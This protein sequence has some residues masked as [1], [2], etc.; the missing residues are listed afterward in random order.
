MAGHPSLADLF[1]SIESISWIIAG[2]RRCPVLPDPRVA[3]P[4]SRFLQLAESFGALV[5]LSRDKDFAK[6]L[7]VMDPNQEHML[8]TDDHVVHEAYGELLN[9]LS[10]L[11][12]KESY[13][14]LSYSRLEGRNGINGYGMYLNPLFK[15]IFDQAKGYVKNKLGDTDDFVKYLDELIPDGKTS[16]NEY[17]GIVDKIARSKVDPGLLEI[18]E[19]ITSYVD[20]RGNLMPIAPDEVPTVQTAF[21]RHQMLNPEDGSSFVIKE[22]LEEALGYTLY[23]EDPQ[24]N[25]SPLRGNSAIDT[26]I[27]NRNIAEFQEWYGTL[28]KKRGHVFFIH[29]ASRLEILLTPEEQKQLTFYSET[30]DSLYQPSTVTFQQQIAEPEARVPWSLS[31]AWDKIK[32]LASDAI[33]GG[34]AIQTQTV[35]F[36]TNYIEMKTKQI[37][38][39]GVLLLGGLNPRVFN[40]LYAPAQRLSTEEFFQRIHEKLEGYVNG[41]NI[42]QF[43]FEQEVETRQSMAEPR[44]QVNP[45]AASFKEDPSDVDESLLDYMKQCHARGRNMYII[46]L[47]HFLRGIGSKPDVEPESHQ[48]FAFVQYMAALYTQHAINNNRSLSSDYLPNAVVKRQR[49]IATTV[50]EKRILLDRALGVDSD[51]RITSFD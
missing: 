16:V 34:P 40:I 5:N 29:Y 18:V 8:I 21:G 28:V 37:D 13:R 38:F 36:I 24:N 11:R 41:L 46:C 6:M 27:R 14:E 42:R 35:N 1:D 33:R 26:V 12:T 30:F 22:V 3:P 47:A 15:Q 50:L 25:L 32:Q 10:E 7:N 48:V 49:I 19:G 4:R 45:A 31:R 20:I 23:S 17:D 2:I 39:I 43:I 9:T 44:I 51:Y